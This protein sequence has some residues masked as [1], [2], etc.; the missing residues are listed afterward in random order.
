MY[1]AHFGDDS[2]VCDDIHEVKESI[3]DH[4]LLTAGF[5][6]Q[7]FSAA[8]K[9]EGIR[10]AVRGTLFSAIVDTLEMSAAGFHFRK[11]KKAT[12]HG[13]GQHFRTILLALTGAGYFV[14]WRLLNAKNFG[15]A[16]N[17]ERVIL[18]GYRDSSGALTC[19]SEE[20]LDRRAILFGK[21]D[22]DGEG[23]LFRLPRISELLKPVRADRKFGIAGF[24]FGNDAYSAPRLPLYKLP[25][26]LRDVLD[27]EVDVRFDFTEA[28]NGWINKNTAV[29]SFVHGVEI[30]SNQEGGRRMGY[31]IFGI[32]GLFAHSYGYH[33]TSL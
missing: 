11:C 21:G 1:K 27:R 20:F 33:V 9:K 30:L 16:Q 2:I 6:C 28:T 12:H 23:S 10:D 5:P 32:G 18:V 3:P 4:D 8:G 31:T 17:R 26:K 14:E 29:N 13:R 19:G 7:P 22:L 25:V 15:L 24:G